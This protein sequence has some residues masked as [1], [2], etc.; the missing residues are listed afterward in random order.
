VFFDQVGASQKHPFQNNIVPTSNVCVKK[1]SNVVTN[2]QANIHKASNSFL[3]KNYTFGFK[4]CVFDFCRLDQKTA[5]QNNIVLQMHGD[6]TQG[7]TVC[8]S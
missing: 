5:F 8:V 2:T 1:N 6:Q 3:T 7:F 4:P